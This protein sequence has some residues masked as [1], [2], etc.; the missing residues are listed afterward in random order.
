MAELDEA[1]KMLD[2]ALEKTGRKALGIQLNYARYACAKNDQAL[3][4][5]MLNEVVSTEDPDPNLRLTNTI[6]K[7]RA[8]RG[9]TKAAMEECGFIQGAVPPAAPAAASAPGAPAK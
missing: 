3:Y 7:R 8:Q 5:K 6:A 4:E 2:H 9:L 1:K